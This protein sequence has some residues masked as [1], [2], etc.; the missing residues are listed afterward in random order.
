MA[1]SLPIPVLRRTG[2][3]VV[4]AVCLLTAASPAAVAHPS[5]KAPRGCGP[6]PA[7]SRSVH[8]LV[9]H[10][11]IAGAAVLGT[12]P[13]PGA[14]C[15]RWTVTDG[16]AELRSGRPMNATG[17]LRV[18]GPPPEPGADPAGREPPRPAPTTGTRR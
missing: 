6:H 4:T 1:I 9:A 11:R 13:A 5:P 3:A 14:A 8:R 10:D 12:G 16:E 7:V 15:A 17:R 18:G 2:L